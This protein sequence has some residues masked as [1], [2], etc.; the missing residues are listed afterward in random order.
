MIL[1]K[2]VKCQGVSEEKHSFMIAT[3]MNHYGATLLT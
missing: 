2:S 1:D 3:P